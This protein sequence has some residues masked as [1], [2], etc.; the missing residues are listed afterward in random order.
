MRHGILAG[1]LILIYEHK[2]V[3][4]SFYETRAQFHGSASRVSWEFASERG[5]STLV[6]LLSVRQAENGDQTLYAQ[7]LAVS[8]AMKLSPALPGLR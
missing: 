4:L 7:N 8:R 2:F 6:G 1:S 3:V 5:Y